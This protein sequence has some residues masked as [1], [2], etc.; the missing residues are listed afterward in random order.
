M[1]NEKKIINAK[2]AVLFERKQKELRKKYKIDNLHNI[3]YNHI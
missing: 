3:W 1:S 2:E